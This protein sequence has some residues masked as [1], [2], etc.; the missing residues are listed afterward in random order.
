MTAEFHDLHPGSKV[1]VTGANGYI[2]SHVINV[3]LELGYK[4]R[5]TVRTPKPW[6][7]EYFDLEYEEGLFETVL[8]PDFQQA[9]ALDKAM[10]GVSGVVHVVCF[11]SLV[12]SIAFI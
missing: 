3:L 4:V 1:L 5:G 9:E 10:D 11:K 7:N 6:L 12:P 2:A 8:V